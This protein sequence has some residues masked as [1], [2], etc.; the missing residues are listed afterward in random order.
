MR[1]GKQREREREGERSCCPCRPPPNQPKGVCELQTSGMA[2]A[3][4]PPSVRLWRNHPLMRPACQPRVALLDCCASPSCC[5]VFSIS[6]S[7]PPLVLPSACSGRSRRRRAHL[8]SFVVRAFVSLLCHLVGCGRCSAA[9]T[10]HSVEPRSR[11]CERAGN[12]DAAAQTQRSPVSCLTSL[13][14]RRVR[15]RPK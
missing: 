5:R 12:S 7:V 4:L 11:S 6:V 2:A 14:G 3:P 13:K 15:A 8:L 10:L 9:R 1:A